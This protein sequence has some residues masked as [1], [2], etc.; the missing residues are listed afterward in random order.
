MPERIDVIGTVRKESPIIFVVD[1]SVNTTPEEKAEIDSFM[2]EVTSLLK[3][4]Y[5][6]IDG[7]KT[8]GVLLFSDKAIW[9]TGSRL[10]PVND[11]VLSY[12]Q[13]EKGEA[14]IETAIEEL[15]AKLSR[16]SFLTSP[17]GYNAPHIIF[18]TNGRLT[19]DDECMK[20]IEAVSSRNRWYQ[21]SRK[22][23]VIA[24]ERA[25]NEDD[26]AWLTGSSEHVIHS[27]D[28]DAL[29]DLMC[30]VTADPVVEIIPPP[31][32]PL[33]DDGIDVHIHD[34][35][36]HIDVNDVLSVKKCEVQITA[37]EHALDPFVEIK[38][39]K[40][41]RP[42]RN[43]DARAG[44][45]WRSAWIPDIDKNLYLKVTNTGDTAIKVR[46]NT[47][48]YRSY[49][50]YECYDFPNIEHLIT[51]TESIELVLQN[52]IEF[53]NVVLRKNEH[54]IQIEDPCG[55]IS[56][57]IIELLPGETCDLEAGDVICN[58]NNER[59][60]MFIPGNDAA[61]A[62]MDIDAFK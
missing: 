42:P 12:V 43:F 60:I 49:E 58:E 46:L 17:F 8:I 26:L 32:S 31:I 44:E 4:E 5:F 38:C 19:I 11:F 1:V 25:V 20:K 56:E 34:Q 54:G 16:L 61:W 29:R 50:K 48:Y 59:L 55:N 23:A 41:E 53:G 52:S 30:E 22:I 39:M 18:V 35:V 37:P 6:C 2:Y 62:D 13:V 28:M 24:G 9:A 21:N 14:H 7:V 47:H 40:R 27:Y 3:D 33:E 45:I 10:V 51:Q 15:G 36:K 57:I